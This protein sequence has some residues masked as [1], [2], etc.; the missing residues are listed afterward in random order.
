MRRVAVV[1]SGIAGLAVAQ[2]LALE[3]RVTLFESD[4][5]FGGHAHTV[6]V[7]LEG[8]THGVDTG[9]LVF[10]ER[11]YPQLID[12]F[13]R[14]GVVTA[15]S[16]MSFSVQ[17]PATGWEWCGSDLNGVFAQR[18]NAISPRFW[19]ML[20]DI[21]RFNRLTTALAQRGADAELDEAIGDFLDRY[22]FGSAFR[23]GYFLP[24][25]GCIWSCPTDQMLRFPVGTMIRFCHNH[26]LIQLTNRPRWH[27]VRGGSTHYV[28]RM[29]DSVSD[30]RQRTPVRALRRTNCA[31]N[32]GVIVRTD[33][34]E[35][36]FDDVV[37]ASHP[38]Q[39][40]ALLTDA[41]AD[42]QQV[43]GAIRYQ[44]N[45]VVLHT[46]ASVLPQRRRAWAAWNY[47]RAAE[48]SRED[49]AV[50]LHYLI[51]R[52]QPLPWRTPVIVSMNPLRP[53]RDE[54]DPGRVDLLA[55]GVRP[56]RAARAARARVD[57]G[58][59]ARLV[60]RRV[61]ALRLSRRR[62]DVGAGGGRGFAQAV[63]S[64]AAFTGLAGRRMTASALLATGRVRHLRLRPTLHG[65]D[66]RTY[67]LLLPLRRLRA[68]PDAA[69]ARNRFGLIA[70]H[71]TDHGDGRVDCLAWLEEQ[72]ANESVTDADGEVWLQ[73]YPR[74]LGYAFK[75][76]SFWYCHRRDG[77]LAAIVAEVNNTFGE[78]HCYLLAGNDVG[79]GR[80]LRARKVF[81]V[82]PFCRVEGSYRFRFARTEDR[83][84]ARI[85]HDDAQGPLLLTSVG[86]TLAPATAQRQWRAFFGQP[87]MTLSVIARIHWH[88]LRLAIKR[89]PFF[90]KPQA[91]PSALSRGSDDAAS[92]NSFV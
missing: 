6:D 38:D 88:A 39:S 63:G 80:E 27:T 45:R 59:L 17:S 89:V 40:L 53:I 71:D 66:Y 79:F 52:L 72:L 82:S 86:G 22:A 73:T 83:I 77:S 20:A 48:R 7:T 58:P 61:D 69:L 74:V 10:N 36:R 24:M 50:C 44:A 51:N 3:A 64:A 14:L 85:E 4:A 54:N 30:K 16:E 67:F 92:S 78:R 56:R 81:H 70:F 55:S 31:T 32:A 15:P 1:G 57:P 87:L 13:A 65:F 90:T 9:F 19:S 76:V 62:A 29:L 35:E 49:S 41:T 5:W 26:G 91:P 28:A 84:V 47:E 25:I 18:R 2:G 21:V 68:Q 34:G 12:L 11:T 42:E 60:L 37:L 8:V 75:P 23:D 46:D 43:L 33:A